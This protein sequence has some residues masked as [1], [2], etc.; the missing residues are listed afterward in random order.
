MEFAF[1]RGLESSKSLSTSAPCAVNEDVVQ[2]PGPSKSSSNGSDADHRAQRISKDSA[3][4]EENCRSLS[5]YTDSTEQSAPIN[6]DMSN[7]V[8]QPPNM[9]KP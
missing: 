8:R 3:M 5:G 2:P 9:A 4:E 1:S 6:F 7:R